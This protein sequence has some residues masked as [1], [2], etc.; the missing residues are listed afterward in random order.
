MISI[1]DYLF[2]GLSDKKIEK[3]YSK[4]DFYKKYFKF[5]DEKK[6]WIVFLPWGAEFETGIKFGLL[7]KQ[8]LVLVYQIQKGFVN[9]DPRIVRKIFK[10]LVKDVDGEISKFEKYSLNVISFSASNGY[11]FYVA[12]EYETDKFM[13]IVTGS[14]LGI[15]V[16]ESKLLKKIRN[17][18][19]ELNFENAE[20]YDGVCGN[21]LPYYH[22]DK[23]PKDTEIWLA[24]FDVHIPFKFGRMIFKKA[25]K[26]N[27]NIKMRCFPCG[28]LFTIFLFGQLNKLKLIN[29]IYKKK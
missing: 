8:G 19:I 27:S 12:N 10:Q 23:L 4:L 13:A 21:I 11:G 17:D 9:K 6:L 3:N 20:C 16:W 7:P 14:K 24:R 22:V 28:H 29:L 5:S 1:L 18:S 26:Y 25:R 2:T 15:E